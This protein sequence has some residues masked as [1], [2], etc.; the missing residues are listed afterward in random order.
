[1]KQELGGKH[2]YRRNGFVEPL[3]KDKAASGDEARKWAREVTAGY[4]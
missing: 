1:M 2:N 4:K 3:R